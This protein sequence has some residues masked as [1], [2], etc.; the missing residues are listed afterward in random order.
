MYGADAYFVSLQVD[1]IYGSLNGPEYNNVLLWQTFFS[2]P[3][4]HRWCCPRRH[5]DR[6]LR[7]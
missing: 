2:H 6:G 3:R 4:C 7:K 1:D 5:Q